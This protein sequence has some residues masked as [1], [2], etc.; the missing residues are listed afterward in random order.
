M[1]R[2]KTIQFW[3]Q[4]HGKVKNQEWIVEPSS[5]TLHKILLPILTSDCEEINGDD[6]DRED[7]HIQEDF[8]LL[9]IGCGTSHFAKEI[10]SLAQKRGK[11]I[12]T[13][14]SEVCI[15]ANKIRDETLI[16]NSN[17]RFDY[18]VFDAI[19]DVNNDDFNGQTFDFI[20]DKGCLDTF[21]FRSETRI[22]NKLAEKLF[23]RIHSLL[24]VSGRYIVITP[25]SKPKV[26]RDFKGFERIHRHVINEGLADL[27]GNKAIV[28]DSNTSKEQNVYMFTCTR[29]D[30]YVAGEG[31]A[32]LDE[33]DKGANEDFE[34]ICQKCGI[35]FDQ[36]FPGLKMARRVR[37]W[38]GHRIHCRK[39]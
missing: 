33:Y 6:R 11:F 18:Q 13:D 22:Q 5:N 28:H 30:N 12:V 34:K 15:Q 10:Y 23:N 32:F 26:L 39:R 1:Q 37:Q 16:Q 17:N 4:H 14:V 35:E 19:S 27:D 25:R 3:D 20:L 9:E 31:G 24:K 36:F 38:K 2:A 29:N 8:A 7:S 21:L